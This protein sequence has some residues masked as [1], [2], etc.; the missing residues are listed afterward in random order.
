MATNF[1]KNGKLPTF[2]VL[3][4]RNGVGYRYLN[5]CINSS[6]DQATSD[7]NLVA[8]DRYLQ[9]S[10]ESTVYNRCRSALG[11]VYLCS[12]S[13]SSYTLLPLARGRHCGAE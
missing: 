12:L 4:F 7:I 3:A 5:V 1:V 9:R 2:V 6:N 13:G 11:L 8:S 10:R